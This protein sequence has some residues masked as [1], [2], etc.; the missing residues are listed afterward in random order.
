MGLKPPF[1][2]LSASTIGGVTKRALQRLGVPTSVFAPHSTRGAAVKMFKSL[3]VPSEVVC[4]L[5]RWKN[6]TAFT[7]HYLRLGAAEK[8]GWALDHF[9]VH[10][11][12]SGFEAEQD[13]SCSPERF[14]DP[15]RSDLDCEAQEQD[16]PTL[17]SLDAIPVF[18]TDPPSRL[19]TQS[20]YTPARPSSPTTKT[21]LRLPQVRLLRPLPAPQAVRKHPRPPL[22]K[23]HISPEKRA[24]PILFLRFAV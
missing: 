1:P 22:Q 8:A 17:P 2:A 24:G 19:A 5:G 18:P 3:G 20:F 9:L 4:E 15:G 16:G 12:P 21:P 6:P 13:K 10:R 11:V 7:E 23:P 14:T